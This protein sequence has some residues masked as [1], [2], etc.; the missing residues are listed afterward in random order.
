MKVKLHIIYN[1]QS[2]ITEQKI[3]DGVSLQ[4][5]VDQFRSSLS[6]A[7]VMSLSTNEKKDEYFILGKRVLENSVYF[8]S[9][10]PDNE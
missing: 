6:G 4:E 10:V 1:G 5:A 8:I 3:E 7:N 9:R 2:F